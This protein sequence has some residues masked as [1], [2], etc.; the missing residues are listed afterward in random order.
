MRARP[1]S[2]EDR[3]REDQITRPRKTQVTIRER[4]SV[5]DHNKRSNDKLPLFLLGWGWG[6]PEEPRATQENPGGEPREAQ[7]NPG[8]P[9][10]TQKSPEE[11]RRAQESPGE[12]RRVQE[13]PG[14]ARRARRAQESPGD[15]RR[16][17]ESPGEGPG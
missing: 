16:A 6:D 13:I 1:K 5:L 11:P 3:D 15:T 7:K 8:K 9:R 14:E 10:G 12:P 17:Q 4:S 2:Q